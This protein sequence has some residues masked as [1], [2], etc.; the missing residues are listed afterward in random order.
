MKITKIKKIEYDLDK[1]S[2]GELW[3]FLDR[4]HNLYLEWYV[5]RESDNYVIID[6]NHKEF[7]RFDSE[8]KM[9]EWSRDK[10]QELENVERFKYKSLKG[11]EDYLGEHFRYTV[12]TVLLN[13]NESM[14][15]HDSG[16]TLITVDGDYL[17]DD[18]VRD[19][20]RYC[21]IN[22]IRELENDD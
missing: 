1:M 18:Q 11:L 16:E 6:R 7:G 5:S 3:N 8:E 13:T 4:W 9:E 10:I 20:L 2:L 17:E 21:L 15:F 19:Q 14:V 12:Y 22:K